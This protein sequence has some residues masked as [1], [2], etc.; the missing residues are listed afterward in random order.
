[1]STARQFFEPEQQPPSQPEQKK[2]QPLWRRAGT[3]IGGGLALLS[4][5]LL[6]SF[7]AVLNSAWFHRYVLAKVQS[8]ASEQLGVSVALQNYAL[9]FSTLS[10]DIYGLTVSGAA[11]YPNPPL[12]QV[13]HAEV[14]VRIVSALQRK[15]Y[16]SS[17]RVDHPVVQVVVDKNGASNLPKLKSSGK[18][19]NTSIFDL[20]IR[21]AVLD[22]GEIFYNDRST[23]LAADLHEVDFHASFNQLEQKYSGALAYRNGSIAFGAYKPLQHDFD[24][25]FELAPTTFQLQRAQISSGASHINLAATATNFNAP[26]VKAQ[27]DV[28]IDGGQFAKLLNNPSIPTGQI[29]AKGSA[30]F[31]QTANQ[32]LLDTLVANGDLTSSQLIVRSGSVGAAINNLVAHYSLADGDATLHDFRANLLGGEITAQGAMKQLAGNSRGELNASLRGISLADATRLAGPSAAKAGVALSGA[33]DAN[34]NASWG[35]TLND[36]VAHVDATIKGDATKRAARLRRVGEASTGSAPGGAVPIDS[37]IHAT[38]TGGNGELAVSQSYLQTPQTSLTMSGTVSKRS[39]LSVRLQA[40]DLREVASLANLFTTPK[41]G[42]TQQPLDLAGRATFQA[43]IQGSIHTPR[44]TGQLSASNL[45]VNGTDWKVVRTSVDASPS[46]VSLLNADL[47]PQSKGRIALNANVGL[48]KWAFTKSSPLQINLDA[49]QMDVAELAKLAG[50]QVPVTGTL[51]THVSLRGS[52]LNPV[53][54]GTL[55]L[56]KVTAYDEPISSLQIRFNGTGDDANADLSIQLPAGTLHGNVSVKP[57]LRTYTAQL[58]SAGIHLD[59]LQALKAKQIVASGVLALNASGQG[60]FDNP[61][62]TATLQI[63]TLAIQKQTIQGLSLK[64]DMANHVADAALTSS[65]V[66]TAIQ[67][68]A[69][70]NL[71]GD[72]LADASLDT[73]GIPIQPLLAAY[74]PAQAASVQGATEVHA[75]LHGPLKNTNLLEAHVT[76]PYLNLSYN[77]SVQLA[78]TSPIHADYQNGVVKIQRSAIHGTD[79]DL[80]FEGSIPVRGNGPMSLLLQ[81]NV[82]LQ[83]A[84]L[85]DPDVRTSGELKFN[86]NSSG[87]T[88]RD[89]G[90]EIDIVDANYAS[91]DLPV[92]LQHGNGVLKLTTNRINI[93]SFQGAIGGGTVTAQGGVAYRPNV[94]FDLGMAA[95]GIRLLYP[96]GM[97]ENIDANIRLA[98]STEN[99]TLGGAVNI[100]DLSFTPAFDL[101]SFA[102]QFSS[103]VAAPPSQGFSQNVN[104]NLSVRST[105]NVNL[106]SRTLSINGSANLQ[107]RGTAADPVI[108]GRVDLSGGDIILN[109]DRFVL[110]N[111]T[112]QFVNPTQTQPVVNV[113]LTTTVQQYNI[114]LRFNGPTDHLQT[115]YTSD[116]A[117]PQ[118]D[119]INL[120][121]FGQTTE[122]SAVASSGTTTTQTGES[123]VASQVSSQITSRLS[124]V[125]GIS[126]LSIS[127]VLG[128]SGSEGNGANITVQQRVTGN[129]FVTFSDN[130]A[131][132]QSQVIQGQYKI[133]PRVS[134]SATRDPNGGF[135]MD[136]LIK[137]SW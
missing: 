117:L 97:R 87:N 46:Q 92:G 36:L 11:P 109:G 38:Y 135:A 123:L 54:N 42:Q 61:Q 19:S 125:A 136:A 91:G 107:V 113:A 102:G 132:T 16:L 65:A 129:L 53:G 75:T 70:V 27:Y 108:L 72:E 37:A 95:K 115:Q 40:N 64:L 96:Q 74:S 77:N 59:E 105:N 48:N 124:K 26:T 104:L 18:K 120:L 44:L 25:Q 118:A 50:R 114:N 98:G 21:R 20:G 122:A 1:M 2:R 127:P 63:P 8:A 101:T 81:G 56:A 84:Q 121:A 39:S 79:T 33:M 23:P 76:I 88:G 69:H 24:S 13:Q 22:Q 28:T 57:K 58:S 62:L 6:V 83:L 128:N 32:P 119:I 47:E 51:S 68:K 106:V 9:H 49:A 4:L 134:L 93:V 14:G 137:K 110:S 30:Q 35:K 89:L 71:T 100:A 29:K 12:L 5:I 133:S 43:T 85:F 52:E 17:F 55:S 45:H 94:Q 31:Q 41:P 73:K 111:G 116:P 60:S 80:Q 7:V 103:G 112:I 67:A 10:L 78:A 66:N 15:W 99:A 90:G 86:I 34:A 131:T 82:N 3:W 126:Q 130:T